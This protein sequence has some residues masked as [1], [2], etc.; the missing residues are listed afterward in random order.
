MVLE[1][2]AHMTVTISTEIWN[3]ELTLANLNFPLGSSME[4]KILARGTS[5]YILASYLSDFQSRHMSSAFFI[6]SIYYNSMTTM[7]ATAYNNIHYEVLD[8][9]RYSMFPCFNSFT[10]V[11][12]RHNLKLT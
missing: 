10:Q 12:L 8:I 9:L 2:I 11:I 4:R 3:I 1:F 7:P 6:P 5:E